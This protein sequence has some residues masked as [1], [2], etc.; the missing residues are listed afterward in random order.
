MGV[1]DKRQITAFFCGSLTGNI[2]PLQLIYSGKSARCHPHFK[3]PPDWHVTHSLRHWSNKETM[4]QYIK[5]IIVPYVESQRDFVGD[6]G[7]F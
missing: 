4:L 2:L 7:Q 3:F 1:N 5:E 6:N